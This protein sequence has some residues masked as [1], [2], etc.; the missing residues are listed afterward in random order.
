LIGDIWQ[1]LR[2]YL[3][4]YSN[5]LRRLFG[6]KCG[7]DISSRFV[8][9]PTNDEIA[10]CVCDKRCHTILDFFGLLR[11]DISRKQVVTAGTSQSLELL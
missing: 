2:R 7:G 9:L 8:M 4:I 10:D 6:P 1:I 3:V 5:F 11:Q